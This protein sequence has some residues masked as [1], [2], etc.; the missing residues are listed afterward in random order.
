[1]KL[2]TYSKQKIFSDDIASVKKALKSNF[3][4]T[5]PTTIIFE[6]KN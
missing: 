3:L 1:M 2:L 6:K 5:G 4:T